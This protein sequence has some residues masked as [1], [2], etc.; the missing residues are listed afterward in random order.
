MPGPGT[1]VGIEQPGSNSQNPDLGSDVLSQPFA[2][3][4]WQ[5]Q[6]RIDMNQNCPVSHKGVQFLPQSYS[7]PALVPENPNNQYQAFSN[8]AIHHP[9]HN[10]PQPITSNLDSISQ[11]GAQKRKHNILTKDSGDELTSQHSNCKETRKKRKSLKLDVDRASGDYQY[12]SDQEPDEDN[13]SR[14]NTYIRCE[15]ARNDGQPCGKLLWIWDRSKPKKLTSTVR[16]HLLK[17]KY[18]SDVTPD[19]TEIACKFGEECTGKKTSVCLKTIDRHI[20]ITFGHYH[21][22]EV[23]KKEEEHDEHG[24]SRVKYRALTAEEKKDWEHSVEITINGGRK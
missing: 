5:V 13:P 19:H 11:S 6:N 24:K 15:W 17:C 3:N 12:T 14:G 18:H 22:Y 9:V 21:Y 4:T 10:M 7:L 23:W 20:S 16:Y 2:P 1:D 8:N